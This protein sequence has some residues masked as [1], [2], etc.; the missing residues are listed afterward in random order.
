VIR[1][2]VTF[3]F[4]DSVTE[5]Q[6]AAL[7]RALDGLPAA[8]P[9][10]VAYHHGPDLGLNPANFAYAVTADFADVDGYTTYRDHPEHQRVIA[11]HITGR[12]TERAAVQL[13][14]TD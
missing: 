7:S 11:E 9:E 10:I 1:H 14:F 4:A 5:E 12:V 3:R 13:E 2:V 6:V 8:I